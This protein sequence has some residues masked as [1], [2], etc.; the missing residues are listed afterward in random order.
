V[1]RFSTPSSQALILAATHEGIIQAGRK[2][3]ALPFQTERRLKDA[4]PI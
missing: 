4:C 3:E 1:D 2:S